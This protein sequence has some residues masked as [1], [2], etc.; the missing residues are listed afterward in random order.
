MNVVNVGSFNPTPA[1]SNGFIR[2]RDGHFYDEKGKRIRFLGVNLAADSAF[3]THSDAEKIAA[4]LH[5]YGFNIVR[6]HHMDA[7]FS[8]INL[9]DRASGDTQHLNK[10]ALDRLDYF[11]FQLKQNG[12]YANINLKVSRTFTE[13]DGLPET[14]K[15]GFSGKPADYFMP[16]MIELQ[17]GFAHDLLTHLNPFTHT[18]Y[19]E[20]PAVAAI[21]IN[22]ENS[23]VGAPWEPIGGGIAGLPPSYR[24]E[25]MRQWNEWLKKKYK[26]TKG[27]KRAWSAEDKPFGP[28]RL[29]NLLSTRFM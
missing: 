7:S 18:S 25:L 9:F 19:A 15:L 2:A 3:P 8:K 1:G 16:R 14:D 28:N 5:K 24:A 21:E 17:K 13:G 22:N 23:I 12:I 29:L 27:L 10:D 4:R 6:L 11:I 26:D 20:D